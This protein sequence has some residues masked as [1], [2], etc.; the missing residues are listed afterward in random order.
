M[1]FTH[2]LRRWL[3]FA[4]M[5]CLMF[6]FGLNAQTIDDLIFLTEQYPPYNFL[7]D[8][9]VRG[10]SV[11][12]LML[13]LEHTKSKQTRNDI[14]LGPWAR[15]YRTVLNRPNTCLFSMTRTDAR[16][17]LFKWVG[18]IILTRIALIAKKDRAITI[19][20]IKD[21][22]PYK[23][24]VVI[25]DIGEQQLQETGLPLTVERL[26]GVDVTR[27]S[28]KKLQAGRIDLWAYE[29]FVAKFAMET[30]GFDPDKYETVY[31]LAEGELYYACHKETP[32]IVIHQLQQ[33]LDDLKA[34]GKLK[35]I[36]NS[37][38]K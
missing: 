27:R 25:D 33:A 30:Y 8:G 22:V 23:I 14:Q 20:A 5:I 4:V 13:I 9:E 19:Q 31:T 6:P 17:P 29:E 3:R 7:E 2:R 34:L 1:R 16:D 38:L 26:A 11:D 10:I 32:S 36:V 37:Y 21:V 28:L 15:G 35:K 24:G 12:L 18:P